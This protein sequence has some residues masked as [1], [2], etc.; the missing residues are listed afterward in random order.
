M[1]TNLEDFALRVLDARGFARAREV[2]D[3]A[4]V[5]ER[6]PLRPLWCL[7]AAALQREIRFS[8]RHALRTGS[9]FTFGTLMDLHRV[10]PA[11]LTE[12]ITR[13]VDIQ[14]PEAMPAE[15][16]ASEYGLPAWMI[17]SY[18]SGW[19]RILKAAR[20]T[21]DLRQAHSDNRVLFEKCFGAEPHGTMEVI[22]GPLG[23]YFRLEDLRD[24]AR[25]AQGKDATEED[26]ERAGNMTGRASVLPKTPVAYPESN[27][28]LIIEKNPDR[29]P[30]WRVADLL[31]HENQHLWFRHVWAPWME[32]STS[33]PPHVDSADV[34][35]GRSDCRA[36]VRKFLP[37]FSA[38]NIDW[39][40][41][42]E[43]LAHIRARWPV[44]E[45]ERALAKPLYDFADRIKGCLVSDDLIGGKAPETLASMIR[46]DL[47]QRHAEIR[48]R[49]FCA[50]TRLT[51]APAV[52]T[53]FVIEYLATGALEDWPQ[54]TDFLLERGMPPAPRKPSPGARSRILV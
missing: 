43:I 31:E 10:N 6:N 1:A 16:Y 51:E 33:F 20:D 5:R 52:D 21:F 18:A 47:V 32:V 45:I 19:R 8:L 17:Q 42:D 48:R 37:V 7:F 15:D 34:G 38:M 54:M 28:G 11:Y 50:T 25:A 35:T 22:Q 26:S 12:E 46:T 39:P 44:H 30:L 23:L 53:D 36:K 49:A 14:L 2:R 40:V 41:K 29:D 13:I 9:G 24:Y 27:A 4:A 3:P